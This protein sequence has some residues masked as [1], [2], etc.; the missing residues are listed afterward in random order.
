MNGGSNICRNRES[1][2]FATVW[3]RE[4]VYHYNEL[5]L[6]TKIFNA[7]GGIYQFEYGE[8]GELVKG[9]CDE[10]GRIRTYTY[11]EQLNCI[12]VVR[13][14]SGTRRIEF[15][16]FCQPLAIINE[17]DSQWRREYDAN[18]NIIA[19]INPLE[20]RREFEY[21]SFGDIIVFRDALGNET[22][23]DWTNSGK[24]NS[25]TRPLGGKSFYLYNERDLLSEITDDFT[26]L[27]RTCQ[28]D[29]ARRIVRIA[30]TNNRRETVSVRRYEYDDQGN[31]ILKTDALGNRTSYSYSGF[32]KLSERIDALG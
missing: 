18:G 24:I 20:A 1:Q 2:K 9:H 8:F 12:G 15:N 28:Y 26:G 31:L 10:V 27:K 23:L 19:T 25:V 32:D 3:A 21:D 5:D 29:D 11:D 7:E 14:D 6:I 30:E 4:T 16:E 13:E 17:E 22:K